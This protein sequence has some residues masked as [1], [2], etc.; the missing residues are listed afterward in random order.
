MGNWQ[1]MR[2]V[3]KTKLSFRLCNDVDARAAVLSQ[4]LNVNFS[5]EKLFRI[6]GPVI[7]R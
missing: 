3:M 7:L 4:M 2:T 6:L 1:R 5:L